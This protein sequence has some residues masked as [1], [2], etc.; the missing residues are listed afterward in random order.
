MPDSYNRCTCKDQSG[1]EAGIRVLPDAGFD[2]V[3]ST[4]LRC[5][6]HRSYKTIAVPRNR[7]HKSWVVGRIAQG[8]PQLPHCGIQS[9]VK[10]DKFMRPN[11][12]TD[13]FSC[14]QFTGALQQKRQDP[15]GLFLQTYMGPRFCK[16]AFAEVNLEGSEASK[17]S[18]G[19]ELLQRHGP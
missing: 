8:F 12:I 2:R 17:P 3:D 1:D 15:K 16:F 7:F 9:G 10:I 13:L 11:L 5:P 19:S 6:S 4:Y 18:C 14:D